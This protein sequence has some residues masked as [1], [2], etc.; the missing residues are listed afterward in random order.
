MLGH[1]RKEG[2]SISV[3]HPSNLWGV[4]METLT[5]IP[6]PALPRQPR[7]HVWRA[8]R[9]RWPVIPQAAGGVHNR[10]GA[11]P[12]GSGWERVRGVS[13]LTPPP[14]VRQG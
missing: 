6:S 3:A 10:A 11:G 14:G 1:L 12:A 7:R 9:E 13:G 8:R 5:L 4:F 2:V